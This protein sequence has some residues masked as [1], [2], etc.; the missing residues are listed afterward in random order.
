MPRVP[1]PSAGLFAVDVEHA[2]RPCVRPP[3]SSYQRR[4]SRTV[5]R[6]GHLT[7]H[8]PST[9]MVAMEKF[10]KVGAL[11]APPVSGGGWR[12]SEFRD[13]RLMKWQGAVR[14]ISRH[15]ISESPRSNR[16]TCRL[17]SAL[18]HSKQTMEVFSNRHTSEGSPKSAT[19][20]LRPPDSGGQASHDAFQV[21]TPRHLMPRLTH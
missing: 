9:T 12:G 5:H 10:D 14:R 21:D 19:T 6:D 8:L 20:L 16:H 18:T 2:N 4:A 1:F 7:T 17:E 3:D 11:V 13:R 15:A